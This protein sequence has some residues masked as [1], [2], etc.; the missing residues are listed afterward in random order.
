M[1]VAVVMMMAVSWPAL[2]TAQQAPAPAPIPT[3]AQPE[4][5][6]IAAEAMP[7]AQTTTPAATTAT[8]AAQTT[9]A[10]ESEEEEGDIVVTGRRPPGSVVGDIPA[11]QVLSPADVRSY[12][13]SSV[14]DLLTELAPQTRSGAGGAPVVLLD[15]KR[16][17]GFQEI[18]DIPT[19]A[20]LRVD[21]LPE[22]VALKYGY[23]ADQKVVNFVLRRRFR[24]TTVELADRAPTEGGSNSPQGDL[25]LLTIRNG[26]RLNIHSKY[27]QSSALTEAERDISVE[28][29]EGATPGYDQRPYRTL[30]P[31]SR[32][33]GT[34]ATYARPIGDVSATLNGELTATQ[35]VGQ[36]GRQ[37]DASG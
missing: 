1:R 26:S 7:T 13:V 16:I 12:G 19:E 35:T 14:S 31:F 32:N 4:A 37:L 20:I 18:R 8:P 2:A 23:T 28:Q 22:E 25:D 34:N 29:T 21:I 10:A 3:P 24:S 11:E 6:P 5:A 27:T 15:G 36:F 30:Q 17:S 33:F 9:P